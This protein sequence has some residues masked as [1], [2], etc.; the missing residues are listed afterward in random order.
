MLVEKCSKQ[1]REQL[2]GLCG[3]VVNN[4]ELVLSQ[5]CSEEIVVA[6]VPLLQ[7]A[8]HSMKDTFVQHPI[9]THMHGV[10][11]PFEM[12]DRDKGAAD[13]SSCG[14]SARERLN[15]QAFVLPSSVLLPVSMRI[16]TV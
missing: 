9:A 7:S 3:H 15:P 8:T 13:T 1:S 6:F 10:D 4:F 2:L 5:E 11:I 16:D 12:E 14:S